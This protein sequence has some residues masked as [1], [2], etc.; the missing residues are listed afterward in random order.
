M[1]LPQSQARE[2]LSGASFITSYSKRVCYSLFTA[3]EEEVPTGSSRKSTSAPCLVSDAV[4]RRFVCK[5][6]FVLA[7]ARACSPLL[8][9]K[10]CSRVCARI[11]AFVYLHVRV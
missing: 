1:S 3:G 6:I 2:S 7:R 8:A 9:P 4:R 5:L 10:V 11:N